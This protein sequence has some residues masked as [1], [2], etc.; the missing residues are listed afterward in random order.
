M[1]ARVRDEREEGFTLIELMI[2]M[3][4]SAMIMTAI[5]GVLVS[6]SNAE[7]RV[8]NFADNQ[9]L[10]RQTIIA[11][12]RDARSSE[13]LKQLDTIQQYKTRID[14]N[15]YDSIDAADATP[16][17][18]IVDEANRELRREVVDNAGNPIA[19]THRLQGVANSST[20]PLF[21]FY[22]ANDNFT[23]QGYYDLNADEPKDVAECTV[24][25]R[26][27]LQAAPNP[28]PSPA[29]LYSDAQLRNRLPGGIGCPQ[30][31]LS[32]ST[33]TTVAP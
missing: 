3:A 5:L 6:Q 26:I 2:T 22:K 1:S 33:T 29:K 12:Q 31:Q 25:I 23:G 30:F 21:A 32:T 27:M 17:R 13:P 9:E 28:G 10:L 8:S 16:I 24:R 14:L 20:N 7:K 18:W 4:L 15:V 11:I 19:V